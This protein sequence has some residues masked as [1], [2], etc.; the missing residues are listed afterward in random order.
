MRF[1]SKPIRRGD[2]LLYENHLFLYSCSHVLSLQV[3]DGLSFYM[4]QGVLH[5]ETIGSDNEEIISS[6]FRAVQR[7]AG[8]ESY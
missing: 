6:A 7:K 8:L 5:V 3:Q 4:E 1:T 2:S